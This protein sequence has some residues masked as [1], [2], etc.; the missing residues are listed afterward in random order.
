LTTPC[1]VLVAA[2]GGCSVW[3]PG[4]TSARTHMTTR[5]RVLSAGWRVCAVALAAAGPGLRGHARTRRGRPG[6]RAKPPAA[7]R[8]HPPTPRSAVSAVSLGLGALGSQLISSGFS[9]SR[10][11]PAA[12]ACARGQPGRRFV[13]RITVTPEA[14]GSPH[15]R[16]DAGVH[17][18]IRAFFNPSRRHRWQW[19]EQ[20]RA[21]LRSRLYIAARRGAS[22]SGS[23]SI[24]LPLPALL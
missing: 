7:F 20:Q 8:I 5:R 6:D 10:R 19:Q 21:R 3:L 11:C 9:A 14:A 22:S 12:R 15:L 1:P 23:S 4:M 18:P 2:G 16:S 13:Y 17:H 24:R